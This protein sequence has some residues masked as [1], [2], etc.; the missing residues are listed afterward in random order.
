[1]GGFDQGA[2]ASAVARLGDG[3]LV[4]FVPA[5]VFAGGQAQETHQ[6]AR[7]L[8]AI[9][10][11]DFSHQGHPVDHTDATKAHEGPHHRLPFPAR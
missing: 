4:T 11:T 9:D 7:A 2:A 3:A 8:K 10:I 6:L 5:G 1:M